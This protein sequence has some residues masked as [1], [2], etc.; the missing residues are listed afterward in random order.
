VVTPADSGR[1]PPRDRARPGIQRAETGA[2]RARLE[3]E[4]P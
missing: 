4:T 2:G 3:T 1:R